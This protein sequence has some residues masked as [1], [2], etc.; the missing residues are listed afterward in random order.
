MD[1]CLYQIMLP[2]AIEPSVGCNVFH[3]AEKVLGYFLIQRL[4]CT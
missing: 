1:A 4:S 2:L 3:C